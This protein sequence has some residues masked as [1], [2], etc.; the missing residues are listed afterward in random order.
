[1][2]GDGINDAPALT[3]ANVGIAMATHGKTTASEVA[4][5]VVLSNGLNAVYDSYFISKRTVY[6]AKQ[7][8]F[9]GIGASLVAMIFSSMGYISP[10]SGAI[11]QEGIDVFVILNALRF[12]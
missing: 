10:L 8:I 4:D 9:I 1:M 2:V 3:Q 12:K 6:L 11:L 5:I 7:S